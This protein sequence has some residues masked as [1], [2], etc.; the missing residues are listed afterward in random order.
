MKHTKS[1]EMPMA[2]DKDLVNSRP[3]LSFHHRCEGN[4]L[5]DKLQVTGLVV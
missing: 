2:C 4:G 1:T 3:L 5:E